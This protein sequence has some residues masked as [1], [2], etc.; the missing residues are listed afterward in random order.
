MRRH[1]RLAGVQ[2]EG[3]RALFM[4]AGDSAVMNKLLGFLTFSQRAYTR[5]KSEWAKRLIDQLTL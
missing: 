5:H 4:F 2:E 3:C 1:E